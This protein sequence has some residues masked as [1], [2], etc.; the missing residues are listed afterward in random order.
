MSVERHKSYLNGRSQTLSMS[1]LTVLS[2]IIY[3]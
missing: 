3:Q 1:M 2:Q